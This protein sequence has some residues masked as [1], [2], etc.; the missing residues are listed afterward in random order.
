MYYWLMR[1]AET[2]KKEF[3]LRYFSGRSELEVLQI[4]MDCCKTGKPYKQPKK[5]TK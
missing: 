3:P 1:Y 4:I 2:F 5:V